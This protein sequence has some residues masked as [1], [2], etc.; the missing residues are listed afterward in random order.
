MGC[1]S[2]LIATRNAAS[3]TQLERSLEGWGYRVTSASDGKSAQELLQATSFDICILDWDMPGISGFEL[4]KQL[5]S[6][7]SDTSPLVILSASPAQLEDA[8]SKKEAGAN[9]YITEPFDLRYVRH[10]MA[11]LAQIVLFRQ[12]LEAA[13]VGESTLSSGTAFS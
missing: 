2:V 9:D 13:H 10:R 12:D 11:G 1:V 4:C 5:R 6:S 3:R 7:R 8:R